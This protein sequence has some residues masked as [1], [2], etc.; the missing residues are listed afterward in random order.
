MN[1]EAHLEAYHDVRDLGPAVQVLLLLLVGEHREHKVSR[2][3]LALP[4][5]EAPYAALLQEQLLCVTAREVAMVPPV[6]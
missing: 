1:G 4:H 2:L 6:W 3:A 5:Q